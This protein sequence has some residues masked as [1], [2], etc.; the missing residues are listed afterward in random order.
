[1]ELVTGTEIC[2]NCGK[3]HANK[4]C[5]FPNYLVN[6]PKCLVVSF[7]GNGHTNPC[8]SAQ[9]SSFRSDVYGR[10]PQPIFKLRIRNANDV[11]HQFNHITGTFVRIDQDSM[12]IHAHAV[13]GAF[14]IKRNQNRQ[15]LIGFDATS[16]KR[17]SLAF[18][19]FSEGAWRLRSRLVVTNSDGILCFPLHTTFE[20]KNGVYRM[21]NDFNLNTVM[22]FGIGA[23][24]NE[25]IVDV[26][27]FANQTGFL[28]NEDDFNGYYGNL[29]WNRITD[30]VIVS[31][32]LGVD[33]RNGD[34][35]YSNTLYEVRPSILCMKFT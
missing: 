23:A 24:D 5:A 15:L 32:T 16:V 14:Q 4:N 6:C 9:V 29:N 18:A 2:C 3:E 11:L 12:C 19:F 10:I 21:P 31:D 8:R 22:I 35:K 30:T 1:M 28:N 27:V 7:D 34:L 17:F 33:Q 26:K 20:H 13:D 25:S